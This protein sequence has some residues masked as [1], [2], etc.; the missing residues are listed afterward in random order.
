MTRKIGTLLL[1]LTFC[2]GGVSRAANSHAASSRSTRSSA[3]RV[4][5]TQQSV[6]LLP[7]QSSTLLPSGQT[8]LTGGEGP[9]GPVSAISIRDHVSGRLSQLGGTLAHARA[10]HTATVLPDGTV[11]ILGGIGP[12]GRVVPTAELFDP[13]GQTVQTIPSIKLTPR[14]FHTATV[15]TSGQLLIAGGVS[16]SGVPVEALEL[17]DFRKNQEIVLSSAALD[18]LSHQAALL[19]DG[20]VLFSGGKNGKGKALVGS[21]VFDPQL[22]N[23]IAVDDPTSLISASG[24]MTEARASSPEDR[25]EN[26]PVDA[27]ISMRFSRPV[28]MPSINGQTVAFTGPN[29][30]VSAKIVAVEGGMLAFLTPTSSLAPGSS[31][32]VKLSGVLDTNNQSVAFAEFG[33]ST[34]GQ[35]PFSAGDE[36]W[37]PTSDWQTHRE[38]SQFESL[39]DLQAGN[40][41]TALAGQVLKLNGMPLENVTLE[42]HGTRTRTD[43]TGRFLL[44]GISKDHQVLVIDGRTANSE[45]KK[46]GLFE[47]GAEIRAGVTNHLGFKIWMP[48]LDMAHEV[49]IPSPTTKET[50]VTTP[51]IPGLE[52]HIPPGTV[53]TDHDG[54]VTTKVSITPIP[55]DRTPFPLPFVKV[56][57]Y[58]T[59]QPGGAYIAMQNKSYKGAQLIYPNT[60]KLAAGIPFAF[61]NYNADHN[62]WYVYGNGHVSPDRTKIVPD[63]GVVI[64]EFSGAM[65]GS[66]SAG[67]ATQGSGLGDGDPVSLSSGLFIYNK[68]DLVV[69]DVIPLTLTRTYRPNDSWSRP[70][71]IGTTHP[72]EMFIGGDGTSFGSTTYI[73]LIL[74]D[75]S[76]I[77]FSGVGTGPS[78][79]SYLSS[80]AG[81]SWYGAVL[82]A[83]PQNVNGYPLAG[84]WFIQTRDGTIYGFPTSDTFINP[85]CQ[86]LIQ[87]TDRFGNQVNITRNAYP[88]CAATQITSP[89]GRY[90]QFQYDTSNRV[91]SATDNS[92]RTVGYTYDGSGRLSTVTDANGGVWT[93][94]YDS[95]ARMLTIEDP[96]SIVYLTNQYDSGGRVTQQ[97]QADSSTY[98]FSWTTTSNTTNDTFTSSWVVGSGPAPYQIT[99]WRSCT[100]C[101]E[102]FGSLISQVDVTDPNGNVR[103]V[104]FNS[105]GQTT[106]DTRAHG[107]TEQQATTYTYYADNLLATA[108]DQLGRV[109]SYSYDVNGNPTQITRLSGTSNAV[110][111]TLLYD[112]LYSQLVSVTD[113]LSH[114]TTFAHDGFDN[115]TAIADPLGHQSTFTSDSQGRITSASDPLGNSTSFGYYQ[116]DLATITDPLSRTTTRFSDAAG[117]LIAATDPSGKTTRLAY[118]TLNQVTSTTDPKGNVTSFN[119]DANGNLLSVTDAN[120]HA[121]TYTYNNMDRVATKTDALTNAESYQYDGNGNLTQ[122][123]DRRGKVTVYTYDGLNRLTFVGYGKTAGPTYE[124]TVTNTYDG[125]SRLTQTVDSVSGT[126]TRAYDGLDRMTSETTPGSNTVS[127]TYDNAGRRASLTVP[128]QSAANYTFDNANRL[129]QIAQGSTTVSFSYDNA[130]RRTT[131]TLPNGIT[132][133]YSYDNGSQLTGITYANG[134]TTLGTLTYGYDLAGR[135][136]SIGGTYAATGLPSAVSTTAYNANNQLTTWG[137]ASLSYDTNGNM[138]GDGTHSYTWDARNH[139]KQIDSGTTASFIY[140]P[141][142]RRTSK[143]IS[144]TSTSF[145]YDGANS[146]KEVI[147]SN[148]ANSLMGGIDEVFQRTD[149]SGARSFLTDALGSTIALTDSSAAFQTTYSYDAFGN[150]TQTGSSTT[151]SFAY[152]GR[153]IDATGLYFYRARYYSPTLQRFIS[154]DPIEFGGG[155]TN[156]YGYTANSPSNHTDPR[157][158]SICTTCAGLPGNPMP[159]RKPASDQ[160]RVPSLAF[161]P[162][163]LAANQFNKFKVG[164][165]GRYPQGTGP[166]GPEEPIGTPNP[167]APPPD[168]V[169]PDLEDPGY[170]PQTPDFW[171]K[172]KYDAAKILELIDTLSNGAGDFIIT[173]STGTCTGLGTSKVASPC[174]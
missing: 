43:E 51:L 37:T 17:W 115:V 106:S 88:T 107:L 45:G 30:D 68:T 125:G 94:T 10:W 166:Q 104:V 155:D 66:G 41:E 1:V 64:Y 158:T 152:T 148:T 62:G 111:T 172:V 133:G 122:F 9:D 72:Y 56:P 23:V 167:N 31:Y 70:F 71:G 91:T 59:I 169:V 22:Q 162:P 7:G 55:L 28:L 173:T 52:L 161:V 130:N 36:D 29:G 78:Y 3:R 53:I 95:S 81:S 128:G 67:P 165:L 12:D 73:D 103:R 164:P 86:A 112:D 48:T 32:D 77:H 119:Y 84:S 13:S 42:I 100:S 5:Q 135:R 153:E 140:D 137:S 35:V 170:V 121:T 2:L 63:P 16:S 101:S 160:N 39:P 108:T 109:T 97:T 60:D 147:G 19:P 90:I 110:T 69:P 141:F 58:F 142:G 54:K 159:G 21:A 154:E 65:V 123:T 145:L 144:S 25:A 92:G 116:A 18:R 26:V 15:L 171:T 113:P 143:T 47:Y 8:L 118:N 85:G 49:T 136:I 74:A 149:S 57:I 151:N 174:N 50:I 157:G 127:Y 79:T 61:W 38:P 34:V 124:S 99:S 93:Y 89:N 102:S 33:F 4:T 156:F 146:V 138:T 131:L 40:S 87:I 6:Q 75:G 24:T 80:S 27:L 46:Y 44:K 11:L 150:T 82:S 83:T 96:R 105:N 14:A 98:Q 134:S 139:L 168:D 132:A 129:T 163:W 76:R 117:R 120:S 20:R 114:T 126:I